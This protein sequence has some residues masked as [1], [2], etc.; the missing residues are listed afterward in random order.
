MS[1]VLSKPVGGQQPVD[2]IVSKSVGE[3]S[4]QSGQATEPMEV[5]ET[6]EKVQPPLEAL[7]NP[8]QVLLSNK[9]VRKVIFYHGFKYSFEKEHNGTEYYKC[10]E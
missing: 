6:V 7:S 1:Q 2:L 5:P 9:G 4:Q 3:L 8:P 10:D